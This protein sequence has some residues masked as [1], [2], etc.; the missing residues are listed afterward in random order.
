LLIFRDANW[1]HP[2]QGGTIIALTTTTYTPLT[3]EIFDADI[4][5][6]SADFDFATNGSSTKMDL[7][8]TAVHEIGHFLGL[9]H[10]DVDGSTMQPEGAIGET[11]KRDLHCDDKN[12]VVFKYPAGETNRYC[13]P[14][15]SCGNCAPPD[16][17][18]HT[19][20]IDVTGEHENG[21]GGCD[22]T[23]G[24][25]LAALVSLLFLGRRRAR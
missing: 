20:T 18:S 1:P 23:G 3:G 12:A 17:L 19:P 14:Q 15:V 7:M 24:G 8:N 6:N 13:D 21:D 11:S 10:S 22:A 4:E 5:F 25:G 2:G 16:T 9:G